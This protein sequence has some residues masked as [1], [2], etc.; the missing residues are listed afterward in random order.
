MPLTRLIKSTSPFW[1]STV[2]GS[3]SNPIF[4]DLYVNVAV[5]NCGSSLAAI[6]RSV[7][8]PLSSFDSSRLNSTDA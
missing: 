6:V 5:L 2:S 3:S 4:D 8:F 1:N 7:A